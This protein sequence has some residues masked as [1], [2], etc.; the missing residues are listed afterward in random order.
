MAQPVTE[1]LVVPQVLGTVRRPRRR[2][3]SAT[4]AAFL[5]PVGVVFVVLYAI[6][7]VKSGWWSFTDANGY[8]TATH[9]IGLANFRKVFSDPEMRSSLRFTVGYTVGTT[10]VITL[11]AIPLAVLLNRRFP[12]RN[13]VRAVFF[14]PS[15]P[16]VAILGLVWGFIL[17][18]L[19]SGVLNSML[20][21]LLGIGPVQWL[22]NDRLAEFSVVLVA[23]W[24]QTGWHALIYLAYL[25]TI[26]QDYYDAARV[27]GAGA[28]RTFF[29]ITLPLLTPAMTISQLFL[30][31]NGLKVYDLPFTLTHG[32]PGFATRTITQGI[33][34]T[35]IAQA[36]VGGAS[37]LAVVFLLIVGLIVA[38]Q[39]L[40]A[41]RLERRYL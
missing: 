17:N 14:F 37:A 4:G 31:T 30:V 2:L 19:G 23:V 27:D 41:R 7:L 29:G 22:A 3:D 40:L 36:D 20:H 34:E 24:A 33:I 8:T 25:Q 6:P 35:G 28:L 39:L 21:T 38:G 18:P 10:V 11:L 32:G 1:A 26:P 12:G 5:L 13:G 9:W 15:V 16:S